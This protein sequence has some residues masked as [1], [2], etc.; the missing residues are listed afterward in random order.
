MRQNNLSLVLYKY[1]TQYQQKTNSKAGFSLI[2]VLVVIALTAMLA[3]FAAPAI[4]FGNNPLKDSSNRIAA[5]FKLARAKAMAQTSAVRIQPV[6]ATEF[7]MERAARCSDTT[8]TNIS[9]RVEKNG[10]FVYEDLSF[11]TPAQLTAV[12]VNSSAVTPVTN[13]N[14]CFNSR[15]IADKTVE[16]TLKDMNTNKQRTMEIFVGGT[17]NLGNIS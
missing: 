6:S 9:D 7:V 11:D 3:A 1:L 12:K 15:G 14:L 16:L 5:S 8:W 10:Q 17:V 13:W 4:T 2:E